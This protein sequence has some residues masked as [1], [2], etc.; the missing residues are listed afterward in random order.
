MKKIALM[1]VCSLVFLS[2]VPAAGLAQE[3]GHIEL[4][5]IAE[6]ETEV[7]DERGETKV[8]RVPA[9]KAFP[10]DEIIFTTTYANISQEE[11]ENVA[12]TNPVPEHMFYR[13]DSAEGEG[14]VITFS[15]DG[16]Q[17][18]DRPANLKITGEDGKERPATPT[19]YTHIR[20]MVRGA[21]PPGKGGSV[22]FRAVIE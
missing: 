18:F 2:M 12:V 10:G 4:S 9:E 1:T 20:W 8:Q 17:T 7:T 16:G 3:R 14:T 5:S 19:E 11:A 15:V 13:T 6:I 21:L 22:S